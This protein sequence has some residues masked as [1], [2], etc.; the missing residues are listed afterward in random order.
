[1]EIRLLGPQTEEGDMTRGRSGHRRGFKG[2]D[3]S[4]RMGRIAVSAPKAMSRTRYPFVIL[5]LVP[6]CA[7]DVN[8]T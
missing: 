8:V 6:L 1:M 4:V 5:E 2:V 3:G 7:L